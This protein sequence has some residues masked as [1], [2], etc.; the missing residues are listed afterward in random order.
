MLPKTIERDFVIVGSGVGGAAAAH[1]LNALGHSVAVVERGHVLSDAE[2]QGIY[3][4]TT[5]H[6]S[7]II[8]RDPVTRFDGKGEY[9]RGFPVVAGGLANVYAGVAMR[10]RQ[11]EFATWPISYDELEP[12]YA[13]SEALMKISGRAGC[14]PT[15][16][17]RS[18]EFPQP[19]PAFQSPWPETLAKAATSMG[20]T[21]FQHPVAIDFQGGCKQCFYCSQVTCP[22]GVRFAPAALIQSLGAGVELFAQ[23]DAV[24]FEF[25]A[26]GKNVEALHAKRC[27]DGADVRFVGASYLVCAGGLQ[28]PRLLGRS[29]LEHTALGRY[30]MLHIL[31]NTIGIFRKPVRQVHSYDKVYSIADYYFDT[32][33]AVRGLI[34]QDVMTPLPKLKEDA[35]RWG[36]IVERWYDRLAQFLTIAEDDAQVENHVDLGSA[37]L[38][39]NHQFSAADEARRRFL[40]KKAAAI[41]RR[42]G[43]FWTIKAKGKSLYHICGT[44]RMGADASDSVTDREG[45]V[46]GTDNL[47]VGDASLMRTSSGVNPSLTVGALALH[48]AESAA[49]SLSTSQRIAQ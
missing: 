8:P 11:E 21:P 31:G 16:P 28:T 4:Q 20:L 25:S 26:D 30:L 29:G 45:R 5:F 12:N 33:G 2:V 7:D 23:H 3:D 47:Y 24:R 42:A 34:Q 48:V 22:V 18:C 39:V 38:R 41:L 40:N 44:A 9:Q 49:A 10:M 13:H 36:P 32:A 37:D 19:L 43:A 15:E 35:G 17:P 6:R 46:W 1:R 14:D 27:G